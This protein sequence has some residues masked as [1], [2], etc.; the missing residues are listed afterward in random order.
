MLP[1]T[2]LLD[3]ENSSAC[4]AQLTPFKKLP[5]VALAGG[6]CSLHPALR[7]EPIRHCLVTIRPLRPMPLEGGFPGLNTSRW[8]LAVG[9]QSV[10]VQ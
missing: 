3:P 7:L 5:L 8:P 4:K 10:L 6:P 1:K 2:P 9:A